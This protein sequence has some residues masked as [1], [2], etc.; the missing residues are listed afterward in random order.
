MINKPLEMRR[1][2]SR[3]LREQRKK[4]EYSQEKL[5]EIS[6]LSVQTINN[7]E[8]GR[9]WLSD[10]TLT[11]LFLALDVDC[12]QILT[13]EFIAQKKLSEALLNNCLD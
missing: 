8:G 10:K 2:L 3:N 5:A 9:K 6:G 4:L 7:I 11:K 12:H 13:P 1:I